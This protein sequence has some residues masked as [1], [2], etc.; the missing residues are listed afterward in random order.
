MIQPDLNLLIYAYNLSAPD[1]TA[2]RSWWEDVMT[3]GME[4][5]LPLGFVRLMTNPRIIQPPQLCQ[6][7][8]AGFPLQTS[9]CCIPPPITGIRWKR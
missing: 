3:W 6:K 7:C 2:A 4:V 1:H 5:G 8:G 9:S